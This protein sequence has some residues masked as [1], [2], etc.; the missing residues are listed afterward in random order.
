MKKISK[1]V[2]LLG[3][4]FILISG[5]IDLD[6]LFNYESQNIPSYITKDNTPVSNPINNQITTLG[7]VLFFIKIYLKIIRWHVLV[8]IN[9]LLLLAIL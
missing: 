2:S 4:L 9:K 7:R 3:L 5:T 1:V 8:V 6:D